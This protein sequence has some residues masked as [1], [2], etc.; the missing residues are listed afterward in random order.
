[1]LLQGGVS[2]RP[3]HFLD[4]LFK[5]AWQPCQQINVSQLSNQLI[6]W[7]F[8]VAAPPMHGCLPGSTTNPHSQTVHACTA[9]PLGQQG[10]FQPQEAACSL[11]HF[12]FYNNIN[13]QP[14]ASCQACCQPWQVY[15]LYTAPKLCA[16]R[17]CGLLSEAG[18][19][20]T[21]TRYHGLLILT[22]KAVQSPGW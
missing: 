4:R 15:T 12:G 14:S 2:D 1:M 3:R 7:Y 10:R 17:S 11:K 16:S 19:C 5:T 13:I 9:V 8:V 20:L 22:T 21:T 6:A 18:R